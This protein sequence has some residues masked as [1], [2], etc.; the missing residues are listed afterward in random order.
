MGGTTCIQGNSG[1]IA[2]SIEMTNIPAAGSMGGRS[3]GMGDVSG[4]RVVSSPQER[5]GIREAL[6][7]LDP[8]CNRK[9]WVK[10]AMSV[11][12]A[13]GD[14]GFEVW[15]EWSSMGSSYSASAAKATW[16]SIKAAGK[17][18][19]ASLY[20]D[21]KASGWPDDAKRT[22]PSADEIQKRKAASAERAAKAELEE[23]Q[24]RE[25]SAVL[26]Q[27]IW[28]SAVELPSHPYTDKKKVP[29]H[30]LRVG[31]WEI[32][33]EET[34]ELITLSNQALLI[35]LMDRSRKIWS[36]QAI[37]PKSAGRRNKDYLKGG[38]KR[39]MFYAIGKAPLKTE[40]GR[41]VFQL[42]EGYATCASAHGANGH[43]TLVCFDV[44]NIR[45]VVAQLR[46]RL[47][48]ALIILLAD[49]DTETDGNPGVST[50]T[51]VAMEFRCLVAV[52]PP[53]DFNDLHRARGLDAV[54][55]CIEAAVLQAQPQAEHM[56]TEV[57][58][59]QE[60]DALKIIVL[61]FQRPHFVIWRKDTASVEV[62]T[63]PE[64]G[65]MAVLQTIAPIELWEQCFDG[66]FKASRG[67]DLIINFAKSLG[68]PDLTRVPSRD[69]VPEVVR[70][71]F[72]V[73]MILRSPNPAASLLA[74]LM[75]LDDRTADTIRYDEFAARLS[76]A[77][78]NNWGGRPGPWSDEHEA[79]LTAYLQHTHGL[80]L[81]TVKVREAAELHGR[82]RTFHPVRDYL[83]GL[84]WD[85]VPRLDRWLVDCLGV[86]YSPYSTAVGA[87]TL[88]AAVARV[89]SPGC[90][91]DHVLCL[92]GAQG[93]GK[94]RAARALAPVVDWFS[95][96]LG[97]P[98]G[99]KDAMVGLKSKWII[100][101]AETAAMTKS[102]KEVV[103]SFLSRCVDTYR[104]PYGRRTE[105]HPRQCV[106]VITVNPA[107]DGSWLDDATGAR[108]FW[109][110]K[111]G[112]CDVDKLIQ[113]RE[114]LW[115]E[116]LVR[117]R[118]G[119]AL[120][121]PQDVEFIARAAQD[122]RQVGNPWDELLDRYLRSN[123]GIKAVTCL[124]VWES[125]NTQPPRSPKDLAPIAQALR[126]RGWTETRLSG[127]PRRRVW[128]PPAPHLATSE[129]S[130]AAAPHD[131][132]AVVSLNRSIQKS[133]NTEVSEGADRLTG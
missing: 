16:K 46:E 43:M 123:T 125:C 90:K 79:Q 39:G 127:K 106:F 42:G 51:A 104:S 105:D 76:C 107:A 116:A 45:A 26:A 59:T 57:S 34:G 63:A 61:G 115:A 31:K 128:H 71:R 86:E 126:A 66:N 83:E 69:C 7:F 117:Y 124:E 11:K 55:D 9:D 118:A 67:S 98:I 130:A 89:Y 17:V 133:C 114:Q 109:P 132:A 94:S 68:E 13:L 74:E 36:L 49:N 72:L 18:T 97:V 60:E 35:P 47:S 28:D 33:R 64:L 119:A 113:I 4:A 65:T 54:N 23:A 22:K 73:A 100:E 96:D 62:C 12:N 29:M 38:A 103:K 27:S 85:S 2:M 129:G 99:H 112:T 95:E 30:G 58:L 93:S 88:I 48:N 80:T 3:E 102:G 111:V 41:P 75:A 15:D 10:Y 70:R 108:R 92:E 101:L 19:I 81:S 77:G 24:A 53:G 52:P 20:R 91:V 110:V 8:N 121:L 5:E 84:R 87:I 6:S 1:A 40:D 120:H 78:S 122:D 50:C 21:A 44:G 131:I 14:S 82:T 32:V 56:V 25:E 37:L